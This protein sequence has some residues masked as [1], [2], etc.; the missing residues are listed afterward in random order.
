[1]SLS[2]GHGDQVDVGEWLW[3]LTHPVPPYEGTSGD[4]DEE[5]AHKGHYSD[6]ER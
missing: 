6:G 5:C 4:D 1:M 3:G 2:P